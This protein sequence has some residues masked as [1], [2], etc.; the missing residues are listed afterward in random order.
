MTQ[1]AFT[2]PAHA[3]A[4]AFGPAVTARRTVQSRVEAAGLCLA[5]VL[6]LLAVGLAIAGR[7]ARAGDVDQHIQDGSI[8]VISDRDAAP[9]TRALSTVWAGDEAAALS[10]ELRA[11]LARNP[12]DDIDDLRRAA[13]DVSRARSM[14]AL[15]SVRARLNENAGAAGDATVSLF[16][17][18][19]LAAI[20]PLIVIRRV[21]DFQVSMAIAVAFVIAGF[22]G[23]HVVRRTIRSTADPLLLPAV[24]A[25]CGIG[26]A[27]MIDLRDPVRDT[28]IAVTFARGVA[29]G[30]ALAALA[31]CVPVERLS[32]QYA[33]LA[34]ALALSV[35][36]IVFGSGPAGSEAKVNL[37][38]VQPV[39]AIRILITLFLAAYFSR[40]WRFLRNLSH[41]GAR[42]VPLLRW[43][44]I[45]PLEYVV[46][47][48]VALTLVALFFVAQRDLGPALVFGCSFLALWA[49]AVRRAGL[50]VAGLAAL[51]AGYWLVVHLGSPAIVA[52][53][54]AMAA[55]PWMNA[56]PGGDQIAQS[57]WGFASGAGIGSGP[58]LGDPQYIR[59]GHTDL[60]LSALGEDFGFVGLLTVTV[61]YGV[62]CHRAIRIALRAPSDFSGFL[63]LGLTFG[64]FIQLLLIGAAVLGV[65]P[66]TG[67]V[68][69]F[70]SYGRSAMTAHL[71]MV[72][73]LLSISGR[74]V[75]GESPRLAVHFAP[76]VRWVVACFAVIAAIALGRAFQVQVWAAD[77]TMAR[78]ALVRLADGTLRFDDNPRLLSAARQ[79][80]VRGTI[81][82]RNGVPL[83]TSDR[84]LVQ[85][86]AQALG[87]LGLDAKDA[88]QTS[89]SRCYPFGGR[90]YHL[91]GDA[92]T[93]LDWTATN[94]SFVE[95]DAGARLLG[96]NDFAAPARIETS[97]RPAVTL[98]RRSYR[99]LV[100]L[101]RHRYQ[102]ENADVVMLRER[103]RDVRLTIDA[104][105]QLR[106]ADILRRGVAA[107]GSSRGAL[108]V[109]DVRT[110]EVLAA[111]SYPWPEDGV[112]TG[113][114]R[115]DPQARLDRVR[116]GVYPPGSTFKL[117]TAA[118]ALT[119]R[120]ELSSSQ[121]MCVRLPDGRIGAR[122]P[123][124]TRPVRDDALDATPH[125]NIG[126]DEAIRHSCNAYF[127]QLGQ[128]LG[129]DP[130]IDMAS[131]FHI[132][133]ARPNTPQRLRP[134]LPYAAFGQGEALASP[135]RLLTVTAAIAGGGQLVEPRWILDSS[136][137]PA[138]AITVLPRAAADRLARDMAMAVTSGTG[139]SLAGVKP[140]I[141]GKTGTA[142]VAGGRSHA[143][144]TGF[145][146][147]GGT[148]GRTIAFVVLVENGGY[149][150]RAAAPIAGELVA[151]ARELDLF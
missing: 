46:P 70:L 137:P 115:F 27:V 59:E 95:E 124:S 139:R 121:F 135:M 38:G 53:R 114:G 60:I 63:A 8:A 16:T 107:A 17:R 25:L 42:H 34:G 78:S 49:V 54:V 97:G 29:I 20:R 116:Y 88:C 18:A 58:G 31:W 39:E 43:I 76:A 47:V 45:P 91:L 142:E 131:R 100:P 61:L 109:M 140:A 92:N 40:K 89:R 149:G 110:G 120:P 19:D 113:N 13:I 96:Y 24:F 143:W 83:A 69:P 32:L 81:S 62:M 150:A 68:T 132:D 33:P 98:T 136:A 1:A 12:I 134:Q 118:A 148:T 2:Y 93:Q 3:S 104:R 10:A 119:L 11:W 9:L 84:A 82:D 55:D 7:S 94:N 106:A 66:L 4:D 102:P 145:A 125:G 128:Q 79:L 30:C 75:A 21:A 6:T 101:A 117:V 22:F 144:F 138:A 146:P 56:R 50:A 108:A 126:L 111:V 90:M 15:R 87:R 64:L 44:A 52:T 133:V 127:A 103:P 67:V 74:T 112:F 14:T 35:L 130:L 28:L 72:G 80:L 122:V 77:E 129:T 86:Q 48:A 105:L 26:L 65:M 123:G 99:E 57:L 73:L 51:A 23:L 141:A 37:W 5:A 41:E 151:A 85:K 36:L 71:V 147:Y